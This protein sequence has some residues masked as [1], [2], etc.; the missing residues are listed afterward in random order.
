VTT[1]DPGNGLSNDTHQEVAMPAENTPA[2][3]TTGIVISLLV[4][5]AVIG[6][7][8]WYLNRNQA[9]GTVAE[10][11][12]ATKSPETKVRKNVPDDNVIDLTEVDTD[13]EVKTEMK[14]RKEK[15]GIDKSLDAVVSSDEV[16]R[17]GENTLSMARIQEE[18]ALKEGRILEEDL[19]PSS[20]ASVSPPAQFGIYIVKKGDNIWNIHF[21]FLKDYF[22]HRGIN[23][24]PRSDEPDHQGFSSGVGKILKFSENLVYIYNLKEKKFDVDLNLIRPMNKIVIYNMQQVFSLLEG[25][26]ADSINAIQFDGDT[27]WLRTE[28]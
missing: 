12:P 7:G 22:D 16:I 13:P 25:I 27:L 24:A 15:Y 5:V 26:D 10:K 2:R 14:R 8:I 4:I 21:R 20:G 3:R 9:P 19:D 28:Q 11:A 1:P 6:A 18:L 23:L 17:I